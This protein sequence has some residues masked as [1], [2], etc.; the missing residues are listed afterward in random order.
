M[1]FATAA[2]LVSELI[3]ARDDKHL[4]RFQKQLASYEL[5]IVDELCYVPLSKIGLV[6]SNL[7][8]EE[9]RRTRAIRK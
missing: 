6:T 1:C 5:L 9:H 4:L 8:F 2:A 3:E 7:P